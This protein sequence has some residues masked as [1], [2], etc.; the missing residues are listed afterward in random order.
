MGLLTTTGAKIVQ[1]YR[2]ILV[3]STNYR[4]DNYYLFLVIL[5]KGEKQ[6][7]TR[8]VSRM[9]SKHSRYFHIM[10]HIKTGKHCYYLFPCID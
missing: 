1:G 6:S 7:V 3:G 10:F 2:H 9:S 5:T 4:K 8:T